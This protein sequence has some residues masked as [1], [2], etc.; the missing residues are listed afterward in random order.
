MKQ[1]L[2]AKYAKMTVC[3]F[4]ILKQLK[5]MGM[6]T[7]EQ[8]TEAATEFN[9][10]KDC[11]DQMLYFKDVVENFKDHENYLK[12]YANMSKTD[13]DDEEDTPVKISSSTQNISKKQPNQSPKSGDIK[14]KTKLSEDEIFSKIMDDTD[15]ESEEESEEEKTP[16]NSKII[17]VKKVKIVVNCY[18]K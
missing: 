8:M 11:E 10:T 14:K 16:V 4:W 5:S 9:L 6:L 7:D 13:P 17:T 12:M 18:K 15:S 3:T 2:P 1:T